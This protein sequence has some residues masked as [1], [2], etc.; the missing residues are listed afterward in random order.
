MFDYIHSIEEKKPNRIHQAILEFQEIC[1]N[2]LINISLATFNN[3]NFHSKLIRNSITYEDLFSIDKSF[4]ELEELEENEIVMNFKNV[5]ELNGNIKFIRC[6]NRCTN[7]V[8]P[9]SN[10]F[11][12]KKAILCELCANLMR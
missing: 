4:E 6:S 8:L 10:H 5:I 9:L 7:R 1:V 2:N 3:D 12:K 11:P